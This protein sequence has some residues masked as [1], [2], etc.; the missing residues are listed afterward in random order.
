MCVSRVG[1]SVTHVRI[2]NNGECLNLLD[3]GGETFATLGELVRYY[4]DENAQ[5]LRDTAGTLISSSSNT[6]FRVS[7]TTANG[8]YNAA[9]HSGCI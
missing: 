7:T 4:T 1:E 5:E 9:T 2:R 8:K 6:R 3:H